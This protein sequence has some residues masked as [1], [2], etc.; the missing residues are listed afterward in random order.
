MVRI[1]AE[2][3]PADVY[4]NYRFFARELLRGIPFGQIGVIDFGRLLFVAEQRHLRAVA[5]FVDARDTPHQILVYGVIL[6]T[7]LAEA[8][9]RAAQN[10]AFD[11]ALIDEF[12]AA[13]E[14]IGKIEEPPVLFA[15]FDHAFH[16]GDP[17][18]AQRA[19]PE[20]HAVVLYGEISLGRVD[21]GRIDGNVLLLHI[22]DVFCDLFDFRDAVVEHARQKFF[23]IIGF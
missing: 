11:H 6:R 21:V 9:E 16:C 19:K 20:A 4:A 3:V 10:Q 17:H 12:R 2:R 15:L 22:G 14:K 7:V 18:T 8:I 1:R 5:L 13:H 23:G